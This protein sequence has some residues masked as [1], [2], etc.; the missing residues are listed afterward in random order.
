ML[1]QEGGGLRKCGYAEACVLRQGRSLLL[2][3]AEPAS[4]TRLLGRLQSR[5]EVSLAEGWR[6]R[7]FLHVLLKEEG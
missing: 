7:D 2:Y 5:T 1:L 4:E 6:P 3:T